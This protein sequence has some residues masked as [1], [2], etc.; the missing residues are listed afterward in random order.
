MLLV[1]IFVIFYYKKEH[2][3][4]GILRVM[5]ATKTDKRLERRYTLSG[6]KR[7]AEVFTFSECSL[8]VF[9]LYSKT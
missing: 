9:C 6:E 1:C 8:F 2:K 5:L 7:D 3:E 4:Y